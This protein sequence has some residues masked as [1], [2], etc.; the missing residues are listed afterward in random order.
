MKNDNNCQFFSEKRIVIN[1]SVTFNS[2]F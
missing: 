1:E 2:N